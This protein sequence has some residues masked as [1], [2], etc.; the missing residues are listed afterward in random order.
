METPVI[1][2]AI[3]C[4]KN[5]QYNLLIGNGSFCIQSVNPF[6]NLVAKAKGAKL[7]L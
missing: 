3:G 4:L 1:G 7:S 6:F 5:P 2:K